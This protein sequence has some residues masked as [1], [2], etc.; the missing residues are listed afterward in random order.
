[1]SEPERLARIETLLEGVTED[2]RETRRCLLGNGQPGL[3]RDVYLLKQEQKTRTWFIRLFIVQS[4]A[5]IGL[6]IK[7]AIS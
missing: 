4:V 5:F 6:I 2:V 1:M 3:V 7:S